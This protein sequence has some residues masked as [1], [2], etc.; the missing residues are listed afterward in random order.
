LSGSGGNRAARRTQEPHREF[1]A[2]VIGEPHRAFYGNHRS[3]VAWSKG[4]V[5]AIAG[6]I[7]TPFVIL[8][9]ITGVVVL[10]VIAWICLPDA[11]GSPR[12]ADRGPDH[13]PSPIRSPVWRIPTNMPCHEDHNYTSNFTALTRRK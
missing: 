4:A 8:A 5:R 11:P 1:A 7:M 13:S 6:V 3:G 10:G 2:A 9:S 12:S